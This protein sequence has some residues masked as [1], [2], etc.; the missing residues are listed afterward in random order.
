MKVEASLFAKCLEEQHAATLRAL[1]AFQPADLDY[2]P[3]EGMRSVRELVHHTYA[4][5]KELASSAALGAPQIID[6]AEAR[7]LGDLA[8]AEEFARQAHLQVLEVLASLSQPQ[9]ERKVKT[10]PG[11]GAGQ[12]C[13][14]EMFRLAVMEQTFHGA[15]LFTYLKLLGRAIPHVYEAA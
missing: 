7:H 1:R 12:H 5:Q 3:A 2:R 10:P 13:A 15:Q 4:A 6:P 9:L 8:Q 11:F 14:W